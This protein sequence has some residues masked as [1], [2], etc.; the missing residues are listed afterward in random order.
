VAPAGSCMADPTAPRCPKVR[1]IVAGAAATGCRALASMPNKSSYTAV[2]APGYSANCATNIGFNEVTTT[3]QRSTSSGTW[4]Q[5]DVAIRSTN[6]AANIG[7]T[8]RFSSCGHRD[9][10]LYRTKA[11][12]YS[13]T[14]GGTAY[15]RTAY[16]Q[17]L[18]SCRPPN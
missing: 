3:L 14:R 11:V 13:R 2:Y 1:K 4:Q 7:A 10:R 17:E 16:A 5:M 18:L 15:T 12:S 9:A 6:S 8:A